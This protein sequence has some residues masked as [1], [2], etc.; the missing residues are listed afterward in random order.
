MEILFY[1]T[2]YL[3]G[4]I[5]IPFGARYGG[6]RPRDDEWGLV[7]FLSFIW[8]ITWM[9]FSFVMIEYFVKWVGGYKENGG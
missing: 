2:I 9:V 7:T 5:S 6:D 4:F 3:I 8:P 1:I